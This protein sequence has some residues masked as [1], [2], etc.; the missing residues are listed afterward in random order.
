MG[1]YKFQQLKF[2]ARVGALLTMFYCYPIMPSNQ[3]ELF[4]SLG[5]DMF[6]SFVPPFFKDTVFPL[7]DLRVR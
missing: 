3:K 1:L 5:Y 7:D 4:S 6:D 2:P